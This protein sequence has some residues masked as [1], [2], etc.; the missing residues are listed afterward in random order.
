MRSF[1]THVA[2]VL[3]LAAAGC[4]SAPIGDASYD[5]PTADAA[6]DGSSVS[7]PPTAGNMPSRDAGNA[8]SSAD[9]SPKATPDAGVA[10]VAPAD[11]SVADGELADSGAPDPTMTGPTMTD[12]DAGATVSMADAG[13]GAGNTAPAA[14]SAADTCPA[15]NGGITFDCEK[16]FLFGENYAWQ[17]WGYDFGGGSSGVA[18]NSSTVKSALQDMQ[19]H[20][21]DVIRWWMFEEINGQNGL[22]LDGSGVPA[23]GA[24]GTLVADIQA[25]LSL[26]AQVGVHYNFTLFS[27]DNFVLTGHTDLAPIITNDANRAK[28]MQFVALVAQTVESDPN[29]DR[30]VS[31]DVINEPEWAIGGMDG[32]VT[33]TVSTGMDPY[34]DPAFNGGTSGKT[35]DLVTFAQMET[36]VRDTVTALHQNSSALVTVGSAA[37]KWNEAW[38]H[39]GLDYYTVHMYDWVNQYYPYT[40]PVSSFGFTLPVVL[41]E[42]PND[43]LTG[44]PFATLMSGIFSNSVGYAGAMAWAYTDKSFPWSGGA[45]NLQAFAASE[46]CVTKF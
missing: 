1:H 12:G 41:G 24:G 2:I 16:R 5:D 27:F 3:I 46:P 25:A 44:V 10:D 32:D 40:T 17:N 34:G 20:G 11:T 4:S 38:M 39:V 30:V 19:S 21:A 35:Y 23:G 14:C 7:P 26:A 22:A 6:A 36:F 8:P 13:S 42:F 9:A 33:S 18:G 28:L 31:W 43:G 15:P 37:A 29:R 45:P